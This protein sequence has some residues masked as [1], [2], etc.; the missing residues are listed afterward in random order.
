MATI[1]NATTGNDILVPT[2]DD[3]TY[4][5][6]SGDDVYILSSAIAANANIS[7]VD[8]A[9]ANRIQ[10]VDGLSIASSRFAADAVELTL[11]NG[12]VVTVNGADNFTFEV[13]GNDTSGTTGTDQTYSG[14]ASAMGVASLPTGSTLLAGTAN[15]SVAGADIGSGVGAGS[16]TVLTTGYD[17]LTGG[18]GNDTYIGV[19]GSGTTL[20]MNSYDVIDGGDGSDTVSLNLSDGNYSGDTTL[21]NIETMSIRASGAARTADVLQQAGIETLTNDRSTQDLTVSGLPNVVDIN[22][23]RVTNAKDT[24]VT[25]DLLALFGEGTS[26]NLDLVKSGASSEIQLQGSTGTTDGIEKL[27]VSV[28]GGAASKA[29]FIKALAASGGASTLTEFHVSGDSKLTVTTAIDFAG[30]AVGALTTGTISAA[31]S[32][33]GVALAATTGENV[34]FVGG[35]GNDSIDFT[36][37]FALYDSVDGGAGTDTIKLNGAASWALNALGSITNTEI[38]QVEGTSGG[39]TTVT[40]MDLA[41]L[42]TIHFVENDTD[43]QAL[44]ASDLKAGDSVG[45]I[46]NNAV[47]PGTV[48]LGLKDASG[49]A[50]SL[51]VTLYGQDAAIA[52]A[53]NAIDDLSIASIETLNIVSDV[54]LT[55]GNEQLKSTEGNTISDLS[56]D[57]ALTTIN[58]SGNDKLIMTVGSEATLL[59]TLDMSGMTYDTTTTLAAGAVNVTL[60]SGNDILNFGT[61]LTSADTVTDGGQRTA[62]TADRLTATIAGLSTVT[63]TGNLNISGVENVD[64]TTITAASSISAASITGASA[65]NVGSANAVNLTI[66]DLPAGLT[67]GV[68]NNAAAA[69]DLFKGKLTVSLADETGT[70]DNI[71]FLLGDTGTNADVDAILVTNATVE[72]V[73]ITASADLTDAAGN[74]HDLDVSLVKAATLVVNGGDALYAE[75]LD[76]TNGGNKTLHVNTAT[77][78]AAAHTGTLDVDANAATP[79]TLTAQGVVAQ[80][81]TGGTKNDTV[82]LTVAG[83]TATH[84]IDG[85]AGTDTVKLSYSGA[86]N[87]ASIQ[88]VENIEV[89]VGASAAGTL[90]QGAATFTN[91]TDAKTLTIKGGNSLST[92]SLGATQA[93]TTQTLTKIDASGFEGRINSLAFADD[94]LV[95]TTQIIGGSSVKDTIAFGSTTDTK[96]FI[97]DIQDIEYLK[98]TH[99][100]GNTSGETTTLNLSKA[101]N[102]SNIYLLTGT[103]AANTVT[104]SNYDPDDHGTVYLGH[105]SATSQ[106]FSADASNT[107]TLTVTHASATGTDDVTN[108]FLLDTNNAT[109]TTSI[110]S[111]GAETLNITVG[112]DAESHNLVIT[113]VTPTTGSKTTVNV[114]GYLATASSA[115]T[116][117]LSTTS[118]GTTTVNAG[119]FAG[120]FSLTDRASVAMTITGSLGVDTIQ[121]EHEGDTIS[122]QTG[123]DSLD[124]NYYA[125]ISGITVDLSKTDDQITSF[126]G[127]ASSG[128][129]TGFENVDLTDYTGGFGANITAGASTAGT[130]ILEGT[131]AS[132][133]IYMGLG[134]DRV[135]YNDTNGASVDTIYNFTKDGATDTII[136]DVSD[137][138]TAGAIISGVTAVMID[139]TSG[140]AAAGTMTIK[141]ASGATT[142]SGAA[143]DL[144]IVVGATFTAATLQT[145]FE[146]SGN[147]VLTI[148]SDAS[149][150]GDTFMTLY[151]DGT[152]AYLAAAVSTTED[153]AN[154]AF[155]ATDLTIVNLVKIS[156]ITSIAAGD[157]AA[158]DFEYVA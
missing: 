60:G 106:G 9:G 88:N 57:T 128:T 118:T 72:Q 92:F 46:Q 137:A 3:V 43:A 96:E 78:N 80:T 14:F 23:D 148:K 95:D 4:R 104:V 71:T 97:L 74:D 150:V 34:T 91:D 26:V 41:T 99:D 109:G 152:D 22:L 27:F 82:D 83:G 114:N 64:I 101:D 47:E 35:S 29:S 93:I 107:S 2:N 139:G 73:T 103:G 100:T 38:L 110:T 111:A 125:I 77:V 24:T 52:L 120:T 75:D 87:V 56:A 10:L 18:A 129:V 142:I 16:T 37:G 124:V 121:M 153:T 94:D 154:T 115:A 113:N 12:A 36:S 147:R 69:T 32:T 79:T 157:F 51:T 126:D 151:S 130:Y 132:D 19:I 144:V 136:V 143:N 63:G 102:V 13:G 53:D 86:A 133:A 39:G 25:F 81:F 44:T 117:T 31:N 108:L 90:T 127:A 42:N 68:G 11:S 155:E 61:T 50:D 28:S 105:A 65:L 49:S 141:E 58:A 59:T 85:G 45:I 30:A 123:V 48:T 54:V 55:L 131:S 146:A 17:E 70:A 145:A 21:T 98:Y 8:T 15:V 66:A 116:L 158:G 6:L 33:G 84:V 119:S 135:I 20:T 112:A 122:A 62:T 134:D 149:D 1:S 89:T 156:G 138:Q 140:A 40:K 5:G 67:V 76:L 7:I